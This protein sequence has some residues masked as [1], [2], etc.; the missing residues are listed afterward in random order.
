MIGLIILSSFGA[1]AGAVAT[2]VGYAK[3]EKVKDIFD[4]VVSKIKK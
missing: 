4:T 2:V 3:N 1:V